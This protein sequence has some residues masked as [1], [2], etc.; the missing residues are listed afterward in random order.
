MTIG[1]AGPARSNSAWHVD[2]RIESQLEFHVTE[3]DV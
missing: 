1:D 3:L 2:V